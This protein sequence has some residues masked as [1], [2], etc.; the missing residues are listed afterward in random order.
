MINA[1]I[2]RV[3]FLLMNLELGE[4]STYIVTFAFHASKV[5]RSIGV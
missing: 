5:L 2:N 1:H 3:E 4:Y